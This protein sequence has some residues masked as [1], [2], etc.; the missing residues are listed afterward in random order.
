MAFSYHGDIW[1][2][3]FRSKEA[4]RLIIHQG[5]ENNPVWNPRGNKIAFSSNRHGNDNVFTT[6]INGGIPKK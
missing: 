2:Y 6:S 4:K 3:T 5:Y 1:V